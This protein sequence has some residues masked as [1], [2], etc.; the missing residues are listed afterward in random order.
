ML[1][2]S[3]MR[4]VIQQA[5]EMSRH[6]INMRTPEGASHQKYLD[7]EN[8]IYHYYYKT[9]ILLLLSGHD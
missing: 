5:R 9:L 7:V 1:R 4:D 8:R 6:F 3:N 2:S